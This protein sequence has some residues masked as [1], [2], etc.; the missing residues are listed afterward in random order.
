MLASFLD[1]THARPCELKYARKWSQV[2]LRRNEAR[3]QFYL[4][5]VF[6]PLQAVHGLTGSEALN[7]TI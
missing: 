2:I 6:Y 1:F 4:G 5:V 3:V 7:S